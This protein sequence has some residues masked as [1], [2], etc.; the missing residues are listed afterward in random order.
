[1]FLVS[2]DTVPLYSICNPPTEALCYAFTGLV[3]EFSRIAK[4]VWS[5]PSPHS[6]LTLGPHTAKND[7][8]LVAQTRFASGNPHMCQQR[9]HQCVCNWPAQGYDW[10]SNK[11]I[12][13]INVQKLRTGN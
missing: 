4:L 13:S 7:G 2:V 9:T 5:R 11:I 1:M 3:L 6:V 8:P 12:V 10:T